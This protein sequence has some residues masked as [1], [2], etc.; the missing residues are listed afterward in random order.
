MSKKERV[1]VTSP[2]EAGFNSTLIVIGMW[3][4]PES[5]LQS[6]DKGVCWGSAPKPKGEKSQQSNYCVLSPF[7]AEPIQPNF[8]LL[9]G[10]C[11]CRLKKGKDSFV[12]LVCLLLSDAEEYSC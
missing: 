8:L 1:R 2:L 9:A 3:V 6:V 11:G 4:C 12:S 5:P 7:F 10:I